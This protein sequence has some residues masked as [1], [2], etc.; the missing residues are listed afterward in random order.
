MKLSRL[1][2]LYKYLNIKVNV[3]VDSSESSSSH[4]SD[5]IIREVKSSHKPHASKTIGIQTGNSIMIH[6]QNSQQ[7]ISGKIP[8]G[9]FGNGVVG[10]IQP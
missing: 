10:Y 2:S 7:T 3:P 4:I 9:H 5:L 6:M 8:A 1:V